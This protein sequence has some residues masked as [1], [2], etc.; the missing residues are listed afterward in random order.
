MPRIRMENILLKQSR[1]K[2]VP[3]EKKGKKAFLHLPIR[4]RPIASAEFGVIVRGRLINHVDQ[5]DRIGPEFYSEPRP[6][7]WM[8]FSVFEVHVVFV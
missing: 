2:A 8:E 7:V 5:F 1:R 4:Y 3:T 6:I